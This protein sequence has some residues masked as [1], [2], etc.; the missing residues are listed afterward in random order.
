MSS[1]TQYLGAKRCC[2]LKVQGPQGPQ[3]AQGAASVGPIGY[4]GYTGAQGYQGATGRGCAGPTGAQGPAGTTGPSGGAQGSQGAVGATG[5]QGL[6]GDTGAQGATGSPGIQGSTGSQGFQGS[7][8]FQGATGAVGPLGVTGSPGIQ[9]AQGATGIQGAT[10]AQGATG[11][12]GIQGSTGSQ[13]FQGSTGF[14][15]AT[16][17]VG[18]LGVTGSPGIQG[19]TGAQGAQ[20]VTGAS[21]WTSMNGI[22][23]STAGYTGI[24]IT[25]QDVLIYGNLLVTGGIDPTYLALTPGPTGPQGFINPLWV[26]NSGNL[27]SEKIYISQ[28]TT[29]ANA[30]LTQSNL[31]INATGLSGLPSLTLNQSGI[32]SG[33]LT[34]EFYNQRTS[35]IGEFNRMSYYAKNSTGT[36]TEFAR[37]YQNA[38][39]ITAGAVKGSIDFAVGNGSGLQ[40]Y[41]SLNANTG[42]VDIFNSDLDLNTNDIVNVPSITTTN[43]NQYSKEQVVYLTANATAPTGGLDSNLRYTAINLGKPAGWIQANSVTTNGFVSGTENITAS[44]DSWDGK[45]WVGTEIGNVY[46][47]SDSGANWTLQGSYGSRIRCFCPYQSGNYMAVGGDF[48]GTYNYLFGI[49]NTSYSSFDITPLSN[50]GMNAPVYTLYN[51]ASNS[52]LYIGGAFT[53]VYNA[54]TNAYDKW[55]TLDYNGNIF[56]SFSN[57][58]GNGFTGGNVYSITKDTA[59]SNFVIVAGDFTGVVVNGSGQFISYLF[60]FATATGEDVTSFFGLGLALNNPCSSVVQNSSSI[61]V[62]GSFTNTQG[63]GSCNTNYG[64]Q[65]YWNGGSWDISDYLFQPSSNIDFITYLPTTGVFY[66][67]VNGLTLYANT[68]QYANIPIGGAWYCVAYNGS[69]TLFAT[70]NQVSAGFLFYQYDQSVG[71]NI[72]SGVWTFNTTGG[73]GFTNCYMTNI[74]SAVEMIW[75]SALSKWFVISQEACSFS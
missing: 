10:G 51:N 61:L 28:S 24:G 42:Q 55:V 66:T 11:S 56:Y 45:W 33:L 3:G 13:G 12:P 74:N 37:I 16:G 6:Q 73:S 22:A 35:Q 39:A 43:N 25:G 63:Y 5:I 9:G 72:S 8:G 70:N 1:Y 58:F 75:N 53:D 26:D 29:G 7:T 62:G 27:R 20:G 4:Q 18:P 69:N 14:Q 31:T 41:L 67:I 34:E 47:S 32:G 54:F 49:Q 65:I 38:E 44:Q 48:T 23:G 40:D 19:S 57:T 50:N 2:D 71:V 21:Q 59:N 64:I 46:Y 52:C 36:K 17:A 15:G 60:T 68:T 30:T